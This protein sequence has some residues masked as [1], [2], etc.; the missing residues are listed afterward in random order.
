MPVTIVDTLIQIEPWVEADFSLLRLMNSYKMM[1]HL[2]GPEQYRQILN[3]HKRYLEMDR[4]GVGHMYTIVL[5]PHR[6]KIG[7]VGF[8]DR[9]W[10]NKLVYEIGWSVLP[11]FQGMG[12]ATIA[13][14]KAITLASFERK[15]KNIHAF[16]SV[17]NLASNK[18]CQKLNFSYMGKCE[19]EYPLGTIMQSNNWRIKF[20]GKNE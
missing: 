3:R 1:Q 10:Q 19:F 15:H 16:P 6:K 12:I 9:S 14:S 17:E 5:L 13:V 7:S 18:I 20:N 8:W 2:G 11:Q 4:L